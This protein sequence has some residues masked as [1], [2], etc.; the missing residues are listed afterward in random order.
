MVESM[1]EE[2]VANSF[3]KMQHRIM[4]RMYTDPSFE[5]IALAYMKRFPKAAKK[6]RVMKKWFNKA[7]AGKT[8]NVLLNKISRNSIPTYQIGFD[9][10]VPGA[11]KTVCLEVNQINWSL[12]KEVAIPSRYLYGYMEESNAQRT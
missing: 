2:S 7:W 4:L 8:S 1:T 10:A 12:S 9:P 11:D 5:N 6:R 3:E